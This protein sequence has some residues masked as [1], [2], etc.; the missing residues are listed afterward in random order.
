VLVRTLHCL[1]EVWLG[2]GDATLAGRVAEEAVALEPFGETGHRL[3]MRA[4]AA[5]GDRAKALLDY[6]RCRS[7]LSEELGVDPSPE[8]SELYL[9][10]LKA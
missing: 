8:T 7:L 6:D 10:I 2:R 9:E 3:L 5:G 1:G 4:H